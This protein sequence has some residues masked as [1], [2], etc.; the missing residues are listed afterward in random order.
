MRTGGCQ[1][2]SVIAMSVAGMQ[3]L[4]AT[5]FLKPQAVASALAW[6]GDHPPA[7]AAALIDRV[8]GA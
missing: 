8:R 2:G 3:Q 6:M 5:M 4:K 7:D 1:C